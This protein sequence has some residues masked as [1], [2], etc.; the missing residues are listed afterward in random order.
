M[1]IA[2]RKLQMTSQT[3]S[4]NVRQF[5]LRFQLEAAALG[6]LLSTPEVKSM[7]TQGL[8]DPVRSLFTSSQPKKDIEDAIPL[9]VLIARAELLETGTQ[10][11]I[12][13]GVI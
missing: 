5:G 7:F 11:S 8:R 2:V 13:S 9:S 3:S 1:E 4:E 10:N 12:T 6:S